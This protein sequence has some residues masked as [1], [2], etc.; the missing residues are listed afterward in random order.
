LTVHGSITSDEINVNQHKWISLASENDSGTVRLFSFNDGELH[1]QQYIYDEDDQQW[2]WGLGKLTAG[3]IKTS[4]IDTTEEENGVIGI[5]APLSFN[6]SVGTA[7]QGLTSQGIGAPPTWTDFH[8]PTS[9]P[10]NPQ[11][12]DIWLAQGE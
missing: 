5:G 1:I 4:W 2:K 7:G 3:G 8:I 6:D 12:G 11:N 9:A 10:A